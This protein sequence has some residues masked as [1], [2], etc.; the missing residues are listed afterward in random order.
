[1][2]VRRLLWGLSL[3]ASSHLVAQ[4]TYQF[5]P[6]QVYGVA[7]DQQ[8]NPVTLRLDLYLPAGASAP[9]PCVVWIHGGAWQGGSRFP[10]PASDF[11]N[12]GY[13]VASI[14]YRLS[15]QS[16][17]PSQLHD[18]RAA[19]RWLRANAGAYNLD[20]DRFGAFG[21]SAG[22]HLSNMLGVTSGLQQARVGQLTVDL[23]GAVGGHLGASSEVQAVVDWFGPTDVLRM[24][25]FPSSMDHDA[26]T[27]PESRVLGQPQQTNPEAANSLSPVTYLWPGAPPTFVMHG[28][29]DA[30]IPY[31]QS[32]YFW[33]RAVA[34]YGL[35]YQFAA[36]SFAGHGGPS[37]D[38]DDARA[39]FDARLADRAS[40]V[41]IAA[42]APISEPSGVGA[43]TISRSGP[44]AAPL[45][46]HLA[47][48]GDVEVGADVACMPAVVTIPAGSASVTLQVQAL[49]DAL[50]EP[51]EE[52]RARVCSSPEHL[53]VAGQGEATLTLQDDDAQGGAP[54]V[55]LVAVDRTMAEPGPDPAIV[56]IARTGSTAQPLSVGVLVRGV[57]TPGV[58]HGQSSGA[59]VIPAG[60]ATL[61]LVIPVVN[62]AESEPTEL[63]V[64]EL[65]AGVDYAL[66]A[67]RVTSGRIFD[68][69]RTAAPVVCLSADGQQLDELGGVVDLL[70][71]RTQL[72]GSLTVNLTVGGDAVVGVDYLISA[73]TVTF[74]PSQPE[75]RV[76]L[77]GLDDALLEGDEELVV[78][79]SP[80]AS[81]TLGVKP[82]QSIP[83]IDDEA[84]VPPLAPATL[85]GGAVA[86]GRSCCMTLVGAPGSIHVTGLA[87]APGYIPAAPY[88]LL[89]ELFGSAT[90]GL[91]VVPASG[92]AVLALAVPENAG[93]VDQKVWMQ[94]A[95]VGAD[96]EFSTRLA[97]Q[98]VMP[99]PR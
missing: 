89:I 6:D 24:S 96:L 15:G 53:V 88:P 85:S 37:F 56:R 98:L 48:R 34:A 43:F 17:W 69:D 16:L 45:D 93:L 74:A 13:A 1:M 81:Y 72:A 59:V 3:L 10:T 51:P 38:V 76:T 27:S 99:A 87:F 70:V 36:A 65:Q 8:G 42:S 35:D 83:L 82:A 21:S 94:S 52:L 57:A 68:D 67:Q 60:A 28:T 44:T 31:E 61:D 78:T 46:V 49:D 95:V 20:P 40:R 63:W 84:V 7:P 71:T 32:E 41:S 62:D 19:V 91:G 39:W 86:I 9:V 11:A 23:E 79:I 14:S 80:S 54:T 64:V 66:G 29:S 22:G 30:T 97:R 90:F 47:L 73:T 12:H 77:T 58:D 18:C 92:A 26:P 33:R 25:Q 50:V 2:S 55:S 5:V 4:N 75:V